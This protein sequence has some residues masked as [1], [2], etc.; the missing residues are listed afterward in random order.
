MEL[1]SGERSPRRQVPGS[2][3]GSPIFHNLGELLRSEE[4][5]GVSGVLRIGQFAVNL[6]WGFGEDSR[7]FLLAAKDWRATAK[8]D[9][10]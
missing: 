4:V 5:R 9:I 3:P 10:D 7:K 1:I 8:N 2:N 6:Q